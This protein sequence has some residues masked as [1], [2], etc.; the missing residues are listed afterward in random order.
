MSPRILVFYGTTD[1]HTRKVAAAIAR[2]I[3]SI[4]L[5]VD[6]VDAKASRRKVTP[7]EYS[8]VIVA[9]SVHAGGYQR[10]V[11]RWVKQ[12]AAELRTR[13]S[14]FVSVCL[15]VLERSPKAARDLGAILQRFFRA[16]EWHPTESKIV[17]GALL[18][19]RYNWLKRWLMR[20]IV[21]KAKGDTDTTRDYEY[22]DWDDLAA[23]AQRFAGEILSARK[24]G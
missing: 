18:Y 19:T 14:A 13:P 20:R 3:Q 12:H 8:G 5:E 17:P 21:A 2:T 4:G 23:F 10:T 1:G 24:A 15:A 7:Q 16:T 22:T 9:A 6:L 11:R